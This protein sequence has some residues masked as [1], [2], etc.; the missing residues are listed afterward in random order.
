M[1]IL[2]IGTANQVSQLIAQNMSGLQISYL[3]NLP[4]SV[5]EASS[6]V[7]PADVVKMRAVRVTLFGRT[8]KTTGLSDQTPKQRQLESVIGFKQLLL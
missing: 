7:N 3:M 4:F 2:N 6:L 8:V 5:A 1:R